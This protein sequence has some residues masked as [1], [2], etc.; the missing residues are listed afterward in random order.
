MTNLNRSS[1]ELTSTVAVI[2]HYRS[3]DTVSQAAVS[4]LTQGLSPDN[5]WLIDNSEEPL[6]RAEMEAGIPAGINVIYAENRGYAAAVNRG[7][8]AIVLTREIPPEFLI[9]ATHETITWPSAVSRLIQTLEQDSSAS[10]AGPTLVSGPEGA[11][12]IWSTGGYLSRFAH[13]PRHLNHRGTFSEAANAKGKPQDRAWLDG[14]FLAYRWTD[15]L[16][17]GLNEDFFLYMEETDFHLRLRRKGKKVVWVP[18]AVVWQSSG[19]IP[20][21]YNARNMRLLFR[22]NEPLWRSALVPFA[23]GKRVAADVLKRRDFS[24]IA[25]SVKGLISRLPPDSAGRPG[26]FVAIVNPLAGALAH[27]ERETIDVLGTNGAAYEVFRTPEPSTGKVSRQQWLV[28]YLSLLAAAARVTRRRGPTARVLVLWP[29]LGYID[30]AILSVLNVRVSLV[31]H[32]PRPLVRSVGYSSWTRRMAHIFG[33]RIE[34][35]T[36]SSLAADVVASDAGSLHQRTI[37]HP[38]LEPKP[39]KTGQPELPIVQVFGQFKPDRDISALAEIARMLDGVAQLRVDGRG[40]PAIPGWVVTSRFV[41]EEEI[42]AL[43]SASAV[44]VIPYRRFF[45]SGVA[46]RALELNV[47][48]VGPR[49]SSLAD[50]VG[51]ESALLTDHALEGAWAN[52][53]SSALRLSPESGLGQGQSWRQRALREWNGWLNS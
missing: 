4:L 3:Y 53:V 33:S 11:E 52:A 7:I 40:W 23:I 19:G 43:I 21:Y 35:I 47:P 14:A 20:A 51:R 38:I 41:P 9:V 45:Q 24:T 22:R 5:V 17:D 10:V 34:I 13:F 50:L 39:S 12:F 48:F 1:A 25:P 16:I 36:H 6:R 46:I 28:N 2:V 8:E 37:A 27:Y 44:I 49:D 26:P 42:D 30:V 29:V 18:Q 32:D 15:V 31:M